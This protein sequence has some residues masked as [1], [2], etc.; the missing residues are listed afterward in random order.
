MALAK[1]V[2]TL[3]GSHEI[4]WRTTS[5]KEDSIEEEVIA[6]NIRRVIFMP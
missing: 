6:Q 2:Q 4:A 3:L 1:Y 5:M